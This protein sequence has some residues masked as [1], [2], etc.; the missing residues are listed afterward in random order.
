[1]KKR[2]SVTPAD[3]ERWRAAGLGQGIG[4]LYKPWLTIRDVPSRGRKSRPWGMTTAREHHL[5]SDNE[6]HF[7]L[8]AD[9]ACEVVDIREQYPLFPQETTQR[10]AAELGIK[11]PRYR[12]SSTP[13]VLTTDFVLTVREHSGNRSLHAYSIK[14]SDELEGKGSSRVL[15]KLE[16]ERRYWLT[17]DVPWKLVTEREFDRVRIMNLEWLSYLARIDDAVLLKCIPDF[18]RFVHREWRGDVPLHTMLA[19][20][21]TRLSLASP[22]DADRLLRHCAWRH[23]ITFDMTRRI[24]PREPL[25][26]VQSSANNL[27]Y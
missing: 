9:H 8:Y 15:E 22:D 14:S 3:I 16:L 26:L 7:F 19:Y 20:A 10:I 18:L 17:H 5:L 13:L 27:M 25:A 6:L 4:A 1:M 12:A 24:T 2:H 23:L 21:A 11:H